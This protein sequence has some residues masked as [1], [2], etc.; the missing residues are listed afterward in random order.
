MVGALVGVGAVGIASIQA[1]AP[2]APDMVVSAP[3]VGAAPE[4]GS[5]ETP[6][7]AGD[8]DLATG[9]GAPMVPE[10][11]ADDVAAASDAG[12][13][14]PLR[15]ETGGTAGLVAPEAP[16]A[17]GGVVVQSDEPV[18]PSPQAALPA[19]PDA[20]DLSISTEPA[21]PPAPEVAE[22]SGFDTSEADV[23]DDG[24]TVVV[25]PDVDAPAAEEEVVSEADTDADAGTETDTAAEE[26]TLAEEEPAQT[27]LLDQ[28]VGSLVD[29]DTPSVPIPDA[30]APEAA[31][32]TE[33]ALEP[34]QDPIDA[35]A[36][37]TEQDAIDPS[38]PMMSIVLIDNGADLSG[39]TVG[40]AALRSFPYPLSFAI[41]ATLPDAAERAA[42]Y[43]AEGLEVLA[44]IDLPAGATPSDAEVGVAA[45]LDA[46]PQAI[47]VLEGVGT[48]FQADRA[49]SD[50]VVGILGGSGHGIV[51]QSKGLNTAQ[52]LALREGIPAATVFRDFDSADQTPTVIRRFLDQAAFRAGQEGGVIMLGRVRPDTISALLLWG[53]QDRA[54]RVALVPVSTLLKAQVDD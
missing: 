13:D 54:E 15:P 33:A 51:M 12:T 34:D 25:V 44:L 5:A 45:A 4:E 23:E 24:V 32:E 21:Q 17:D 36:F 7:M 41:D 48:G 8:A 42:A 11:Q 29:R 18:L 31:A 52:K 28:R 1:D 22:D 2:A 10:P 6:Q 26:D 50:Q 19:Q 47:G 16:V 27:P 49:L 14:T 3:V 40:L 9:A 35:Y 46:V 20:D 43:R 37:M 38:K 30:Q 53:L 39:G